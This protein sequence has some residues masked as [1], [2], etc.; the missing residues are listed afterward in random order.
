[1]T[2]ESKLKLTLF[3]ALLAAAV[4]LGIW[5]D[6]GSRER[7]VVRGIVIDSEPGGSSPKSPGI[8]PAKIKARLPDGRTVDVATTSARSVTTGSEIEISE[9]VTP[10]GVVWFKYKD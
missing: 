1:M 5:R 7:S 2:I 4:A 3:F 8:T 10:W 6:L 9:R